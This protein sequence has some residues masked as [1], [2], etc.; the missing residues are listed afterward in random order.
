MKSV[1]IADQRFGKLLAFYR[2]GVDEKGQVL[3]ICLCDC[4]G[5]T[6]TACAKLRIGHAQSC[7]CGRADA[8][9]KHGHT[10]QRRQSPE[11]RTWRNMINRCRDLL[12]ASY[13]NYGGRGIRVCEEWL[14][15]FEAFLAHVGLK[16][17]PQ[18]TLDRFPDNNGNY[19][20]GNVRWATRKEQ[21]NNRRP[22]RRLRRPAS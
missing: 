13:E 22:R 17:T 12:A 3:W 10:R 8:I 14:N 20:P 7:G 11:Y 4:G 9:T 1:G 16:P 19:E 15:S 18:H 6:I 2:F 21:A 5:G